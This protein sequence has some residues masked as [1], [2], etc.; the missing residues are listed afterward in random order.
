MFITD[1]RSCAVA[2]MTAYVVMFWKIV[3]KGQEHSWLMLLQRGRDEFVPEDGLGPEYGDPDTRFRR[4]NV[5][6]GTVRNIFGL[7]MSG[8]EIN[9]QCGNPLERRDC[10]G[11]Y[12]RSRVDYKAPVSPVLPTNAREG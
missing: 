5:I 2:P 3:P 1:P 9:P 12:L 10:F 6:T 4:A 7:R 11:L 8:N